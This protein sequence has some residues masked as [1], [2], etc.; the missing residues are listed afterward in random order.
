MSRKHKTLFLDGSG[1]FNSFENPYFLQDNETIDSVDTWP[2]FNGLMKSR[3]AFDV[4]RDDNTLAMKEY[5]NGAIID[6]YVHDDVIYTLTLGRMFANGVSRDTSI[7]TSKNGAIKFLGYFNNKI[8]YTDGNESIKSYNIANN[9]ISNVKTFDYPP[10]AWVFF[11]NR[12]FISCAGDKG[13]VYYSPFNSDASFND[14]IDI[15]ENSEIMDMFVLNQAIMISTVSNKIFALTGRSKLS[16]SISPIMS[17]FAS[18][19][20]G[21]TIWNNAVVFEN[22]IDRRLYYWDGYGLP[23]RIDT[24]VLRGPR[25]MVSDMSKT[26]FYDKRRG[27]VY[28]EFYISTP[29]ETGGPFYA[30]NLTSRK[31]I[32]CSKWFLGDPPTSDFYPIHNNGYF[33]FGERHI[34]R[35]RESDGN[36]FFDRY[37]DIHGA[38]PTKILPRCRLKPFALAGIMQDSRPLGL[39]MASQ[40]SAQYR[41]D[42]TA[43]GQKIKTQ[44]I[45]LNVGPDLMPDTP[46]IS[47]TKFNA[48]SLADRH[49]QLD[50]TTQDIPDWPI[51]EDAS[52]PTVWDWYNADGSI[53]C[54]NSNVLRNTDD[55]S[56]VAVISFD[57]ITSYSRVNGGPKKSNHHYYMGKVTT[58]NI[59][60]TVDDYFIYKLN[61][62]TGSLFSI[63]IEDEPKG[64][65]KAWGSLTG[66]FIVYESKDNGECVSFDI[67]NEVKSAKETVA[68]PAMATAWHPTK[69]QYY[70]AKSGDNYLYRVNAADLTTIQKQKEWQGSVNE[71]VLIRAGVDNKLYIGIKA[72]PFIIVYDE[73]L[74]LKYKDQYNYRKVF[75]KSSAEAS[76]YYPLDDYEYYEIDTGQFKPK[77]DLP[78]LPPFV[79]AMADTITVKRG[80]QTLIKTY[81][82]AT[83][84]E[85]PTQI[86]A[87]GLAFD[88]EVL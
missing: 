2:G 41:F 84:K 68:S 55:D 35:I 26:P 14:Y 36:T 31:K 37:D 79:L 74:T 21:S 27:F 63:P 53:Y 85:R 65:D 83:V 5:A 78:K 23:K 67:I 80:N 70:S 72:Q 24:D 86:S 28:K 8:Y 82:P 64:L 50:I 49:I 61:M 52:L 45:T 58:D 20:L 3:P 29:V 38:Q 44:S 6:L 1:G 16:F 54:D 15:P 81:N 88:A 62:N 76:Q 57:G 60:I 46:L 40:G 32:A 18:S 69:P 47:E 56:Q 59:S 39:T 77:T 22:Y 11:E 10:R 17:G 73:D 48:M 13:R 19:S 12:I 30:F 87:L 34:A 42:I 9:S 51:N 43:L 7:S 25:H 75:M 66:D 4:L 33:C 71:E